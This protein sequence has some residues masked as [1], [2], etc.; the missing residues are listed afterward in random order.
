MYRANLMTR[1]PVA[2]LLAVALAAG[3]AGCRKTPAPSADA[4]AVVNGKEIK[5]EDV[6]KQFRAR[7]DPDRQEP[8][9]EE[10]WTLKLSILEELINNEILLERARRLGLEASDGEVE[11]R[12]TEM[13]APFTEEEFQRQLKERDLTVEDLKKQ[14][15]QQLSVQKVLNR[16]VVAKVTI[17]DQEIADHYNENRALFNLSEPTYRLAQIVVTPWADPQV[18][19]RRGDDAATD[20]EA[21]RKAASLLE[22]IQAGADFAELAIDFSEDPSTAANGG[23]LGFVPESALANTDPATQRVVRQL[24][25]GEVSGVISAGGIY[26]IIR[27]ISR[28]PAGQR[29]LSDPRVQSAIRDTLRNRKEQLLRS[30]FLTVARDEAEV[31]NL[32]AKQVLESAG[33]MP[34]PAAAR[35]AEETAPAGQPPPSK[36]DQ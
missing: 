1:I 19:N 26:R 33:K 24:R 12:F 3:A 31:Q 22:R 13:K 30:A 10:A 28:E 15:R 36:T 9:I 7:M 5:R 29:E 2:M 23:D 35:S 32:L 25:P 6:E 18:R 20:A 16:E 4:W 8:S 34:A 21:R 11:D 14:L 27:L 17:T